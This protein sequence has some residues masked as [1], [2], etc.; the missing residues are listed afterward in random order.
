MHMHNWDMRDDRSF[1]QLVQL[2]QKLQDWEI[3]TGVQV[4][5]VSLATVYNGKD[6]LDALLL[7]Q[8]ADELPICEGRLLPDM[9]SSIGILLGKLLEDGKNPFRLLLPLNRPATFVVILKLIETILQCSCEKTTQT[10][11]K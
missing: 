7:C 2:I 9:W 3:D 1:L 11:K 10:D 4:Q 6:V 5:I 8:E